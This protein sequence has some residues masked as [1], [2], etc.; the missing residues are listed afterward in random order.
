MNQKILFLV[1]FLLFS[2]QSFAGGWRMRA[3][4]HYE[5]HNIELN[6]NRTAEYR[7]LSNT[8]NIWYEEPLEWA[9]GLAGGPVLGSAKKQQDTLLTELGDTV[10]LY[11]VGLE[12]KYFHFKSLPG[13][14]SRL[15]LSWN[16]LNS[17]GTIKHSPGWGFYTG[18]GWEFPLKYFSI[19]P[20]IAMRNTY[21][22]N[23]ILIMS[24]T[25]SIAFHFHNIF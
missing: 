24:F 13:F 20:E 16:Q 22:E 7:G 10:Q 15:G 5:I 2:E 1:I 8:I 25:P 11:T 19:V 21:L 14:F 12:L 6:T 17:K 23:H 4:E 3:R 9:F 18:L